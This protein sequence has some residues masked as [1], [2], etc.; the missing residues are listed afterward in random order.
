MFFVSYVSC[1]KLYY[2][3]WADLESSFKSVLQCEFIFL[4]LNDSDFNIYLTN[5]VKGFLLF[6][7]FSFQRTKTYKKHAAQEQ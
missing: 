3:T 4:K 5:G 6:T 7:I 1:L 2:R